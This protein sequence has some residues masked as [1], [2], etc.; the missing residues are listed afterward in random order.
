MPTKPGTGSSLFGECS[1]KDVNVILATIAREKDEA[2][3]PMDGWI[4]S[5]GSVCLTVVA[6]KRRSRGVINS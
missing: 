6:R 4:D 5:R 3:C 2:S 1:E